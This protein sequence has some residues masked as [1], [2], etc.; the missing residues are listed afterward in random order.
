MFH[1]TVSPHELNTVLV[2]C[3]MTGAYISHDG[4]KSW[5]M[6]NLRGVVQFFVFDPLD[7]NV[8]YAESNGLWRSEDQGVTWNLIYPKPSLIR[9]VKMSSD[10]SDEDIVA[11]P[12]PLGSITAM[13]IDPSDSKVLYVTAGDRKK[14]T[15]SL[16]ASRDSGQSWTKEADLPALAKKIWVNPSSPSNGRTLLIAGEDFI[17]EKT[18]SGMRKI[19]APP[20]KTITD[21]SAGFTKD[22]KGIVYAIGDEAAFVSDDEGVAWRKV[23]L[24]A[25]KGK[26]RA[27]A[28]SLHNPDTAYVSYNGLEENG[29]KWL[30]VA[31]TTDAG[32]T[33]NLVWKEDSSPAA[34]SGAN[35]HDAWITER[36]GTDWGENPLALTVADQDANVSYGTDLGRTMRTTDGGAN[37]VAVYSKR[38]GSGWFSTGLDVTNAYGYHFDPFDHNRQFISTTDIGLFRS[39]DGGKSWASSTQGVPKE[40]INTTYWIVFDP[41]VKGRVWSVNSWTHDLPRPKMWRRK[42]ILDYRGGVCRSEDG[43]RTWTKSNNGMEPTAATHILLDP[44]SPPDA[45]V[46]YVAAFGRGVYKS[47]DGGKSWTLKNAGITQKEPFAW[48]IVRDARGALYVLVARRSEDGSIGNDGD[49]ATYRSTDGAEHWTPVAMPQGSNAPNGL[50]VDPHDSNRLYLASWARDKGEHGD[51]GGIFLSADA[52]ETWRQ[53]LER[54][55]HVYDVTIDPRDAS[56]LYAAGFESSAWRST[57]RGEHWTRIPGF[58]FKWGHRVIPDPENAKMVYITTFGGGV[59]YGSVDGEDRPLDIV[60]PQLQP[61]R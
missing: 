3:D 52:G 7:K 39:E 21:M 23:T 20:V 31:K 18:S 25:G 26:L 28:T 61:G 6:F 60:T 34:K 59:W 2:S 30:G 9:H 57:D 56:I 4:G 53:V 47:I 22:G 12:N 49:G 55:R 19:P 43:G 27:I 48:R 32:R 35:V 58:N 10:H 51:G 29:V 8:I 36:F 54:D 1:P 15:S 5:R 45:R 24:G 37:W 42:T 50:A 17:A 13:A 16:F 33:W 41:A 38:E 14:G 46:L 11:E 44:T 40:W